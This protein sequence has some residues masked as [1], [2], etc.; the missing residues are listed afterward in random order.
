MLVC[1]E[2]IVTDVALTVMMVVVDLG[3][4]RALV[5]DQAQVNGLLVAVI[6]DCQAV[7]RTVQDS[8]GDVD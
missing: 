6:A 3:A 7:V 4:Y 5:R 1:S 8:T 2:M